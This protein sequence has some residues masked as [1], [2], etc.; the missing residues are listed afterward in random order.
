MNYL[1]RNT[2]QVSSRMVGKSLAQFLGN[3]DLKLI[4]IGARGDSLPDLLVLA[5]FSHFVACEPETDAYTQ[6]SGGQETGPW[7]NLTL[8]RE[9][10]ATDPKQNRLNITREPGYTSLLMPEPDVFGKYFSDNSY[11]V[12]STEDVRI[13]SLDDASDKYNFTDACFIKVDTQGSELDILKSGKNLLRNSILGVYVE[14]EFHPFYKDQP[15]FSDV[16]AYL[17][18]LG[19]SLFDLYKSSFRRVNYRSDLYSRRQVVWAHAFYLKELP[20]EQSSA[21]ELSRLFALAM[22]FEHYD[23]AFDLVTSEPLAPQIQK[24]YGQE[25][26][27]DLET[28]VKARTKTALKTTT[29]AKNHLTFGRKEKPDRFE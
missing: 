10:I 5:P 19:F 16:D 11:D 28:L 18:S 13:I 12:V 24:E 25:L 2:H 21:L 27:T 14:V 29:P 4:D 22:A 15:L 6:L 20:S 8:I 17:R 26:Y 1:T 23:L 3:V 9:A 7:R